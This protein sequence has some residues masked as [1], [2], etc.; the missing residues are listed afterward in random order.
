MSNFTPKK[1]GM[2]CDAAPGAKCECCQH[3]RPFG[4]KE[5]Y[6]EPCVFRRIDVRAQT[7]VDLMY[8]CVKRSLLPIPVG[9]GG[10]E[11]KVQLDF[12]TTALRDKL[13]MHGVPEEFH[14]EIDDL[15]T[16]AFLEYRMLTDKK[17]VSFDPSLIRELG[18]WQT[19]P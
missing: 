5:E 3:K 1:C 7:L 6:C 18:E 4:W 8:S 11:I 15:V 19:D 12:S 10:S 13:C 9:L 14:G 2:E 17:S 16:A